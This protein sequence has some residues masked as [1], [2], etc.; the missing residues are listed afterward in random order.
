MKAQLRQCGACVGL[1]GGGKLDP[2]PAAHY[3]S[4]G[5]DLRKGPDHVEDFALRED[6][7]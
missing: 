3:L 6:T 5:E 1:G 2:E 7:I 4:G